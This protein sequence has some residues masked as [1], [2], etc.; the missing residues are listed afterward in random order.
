MCVIL[1]FTIELRILGIDLILANKG[2]LEVCALKSYLL[3]RDLGVCSFKCFPY[4]HF[5]KYKKYNKV[6][7]VENSKKEYLCKASDRN[8]TRSEGWHKSG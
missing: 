4:P 7:L 8:G 3:R 2:D 5:F 1:P 6:K